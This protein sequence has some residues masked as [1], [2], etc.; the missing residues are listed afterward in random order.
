MHDNCRATVGG[1]LNAALIPYTSG[2]SNL[3][4]VIEILKK[5]LEFFVTNVAIVNDVHAGK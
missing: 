4:L 3:P 2:V 5:L 1:I